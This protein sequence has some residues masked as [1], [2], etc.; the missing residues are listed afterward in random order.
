MEGAGNSSSRVERNMKE[1]VRRKEMTNLLSQLA[2]LIKPQQ[3]SKVSG[4]ELLDHAANYI[5]RLQER[6]EEQKGRHETLLKESPCDPNYKKTTSSCSSPVLNIKSC[7]DSTCLEV[8]LICGLNNNL[9]LHE[10]ISVLQQ[11]GAE[12]MNLTQNNEGDR[13]IFTIT[14][15]VYIRCYII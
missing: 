10:I 3:T 5:K 6:V 2:F 9:L 12:V 11:E 15:Q 14:S 13:V 8:N 1:R 7:E 4:P